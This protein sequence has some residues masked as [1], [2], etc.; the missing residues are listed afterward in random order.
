MVQEL[1]LTDQDISAIAEMIESEIRSCFPDWELTDHE[2]NE[3]DFDSTSDSRYE[4]PSPSTNKSG[5]SPG[6]LSLEHLPS[7]RKYWSDA[8]KSGGSPLDPILSDG[9]DQGS[10]HGDPTEK[11]EEFLHND[12][13]NKNVDVIVHTLGNI[14][15]EKKKEENELKNQHDPTRKTEEFLQD[16]EDNENVDVIANKL[17]NIMIEEKKEDD[18]LKKQHDPTGKTEELL[19][20]DED[21]EN[22]DFIVE[23]LGNIMI[24]QKKEEDELK[25]QHE[26]IVNEILMKLPP[27]TRQEVVR[28][29]KSEIMK[30]CILDKNVTESDHTFDT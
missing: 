5:A 6:S 21:N 7:G 9:E 19:Q 12:V 20:D 2:V 8:P 11:T 25:K 29:C 14:T 26:L 17:G 24:E 28:A 15:I 10:T 23:K 1:D 3:V 30:T 4:S 22:V 16:D 13:D 27:E 18:E